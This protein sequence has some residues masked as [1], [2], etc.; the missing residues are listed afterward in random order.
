M[1]S[2]QPAA[3]SSSDSVSTCRTRRSRP[4]PSAMRTAISRCRAAPRAS[5]KVATLVHAS[6][7]SRLT[8]AISANSGLA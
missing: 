3:E 6:N 1:P 5:N 2:R 7:K 4:A 8:I